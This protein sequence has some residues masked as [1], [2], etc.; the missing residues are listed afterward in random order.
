MLLMEDISKLCRGLF[1]Y[2]C[3]HIYREATRNID[4][5]AEKGIGILDFY[6]WWSNFPEDVTNISYENYCGSRFNRLYIF[7]FQNQD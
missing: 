7:M 5:L 3:C 2:E 4:C 6:W 1:I